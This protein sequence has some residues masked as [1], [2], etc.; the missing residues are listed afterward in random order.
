[1][2]KDPNIERI[3]RE[4]DAAMLDRLEE[5]TISLSG[6]K[7]IVVVSINEKAPCKVDSSIIDESETYIVSKKEKITI[8]NL[9]EIIISKS[10]T[11]V[12]QV[13]SEICVYSIG[14]VRITG[15]KIYLDKAK[16]ALEKYEWDGKADRVMVCIYF[17]DGRKIEILQTKECWGKQIVIFADYL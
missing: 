7:R 13:I 14:V 4:I 3:K 9:V 15:D 17:K 8:E 11:P 1:M 12:S 6:K 16:E 5:I 2:K 10:K